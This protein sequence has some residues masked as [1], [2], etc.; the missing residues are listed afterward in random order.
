MKIK[1]KISKSMRV[2]SPDFTGIL[3]PCII[4]N[5][6]FINKLSNEEDV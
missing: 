3:V 5:H 2:A 6:D 4:N 1:S